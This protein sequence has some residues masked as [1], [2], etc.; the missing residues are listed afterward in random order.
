MNK[1]RTTAFMQLIAY[2]GAYLLPTRRACLSH[3][4]GNMQGIWQ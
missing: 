1:T 3:A 2:I 4:D